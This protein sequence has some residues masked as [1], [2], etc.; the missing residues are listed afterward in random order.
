MTFQNGAKKE[1]A[2]VKL[3]P[4]L[5]KVAEDSIKSE[6]PSV[7]KR[8]SGYEWSDDQAGWTDAL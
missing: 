6:L 4:G 5:Y 1:N 8:R 3:N 2:E 7:D